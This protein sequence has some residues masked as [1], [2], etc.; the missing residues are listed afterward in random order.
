MTSHI[1]EWVPKTG[2][3]RMHAGHWA[4]CVSCQRAAEKHAVEMGYAED[5]RKNP[6]VTKSLA[7]FDMM[8][9]NR[10]LSD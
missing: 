10:R 9:N 3:F 4:D 5:L 8:R 7:H 2:K 1:V 6:K